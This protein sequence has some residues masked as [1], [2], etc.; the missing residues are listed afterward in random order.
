MGA[1]DR[2][3]EVVDRL[4]LGEAPPHRDGLR[5]PDG[6]KADLAR[7]VEAGETIRWA[8]WIYAARG[9]G[10]HDGLHESAAVVTD[11]R[12]VWVP[13][14]EAL[15]VDREALDDVTR[16]MVD[17]KSNRLLLVTD[18]HDLDSPG[19]AV[20]F[21]YERDLHDAIQSARGFPVPDA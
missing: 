16:L 8:G 4:P 10:P 15:P 1:L 21:Q 17:R 6:A 19:I 2:F 12:V 11:R 14:L 13:L 3:R 20:L 9:A 5:S 7:D 18:E